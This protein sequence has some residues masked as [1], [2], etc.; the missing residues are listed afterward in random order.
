MVLV[1][2][3]KERKQETTFLLAQAAYQWQ[4]SLTHNQLHAGYKTHICQKVICP[5][6]SSHIH[7]I[8]STSHWLYCFLSLDVCVNQ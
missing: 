3:G 2:L 5:P 7:H 4:V 8:S 1:A 6:S